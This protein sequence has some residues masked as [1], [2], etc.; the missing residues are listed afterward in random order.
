MGGM[1]EKGVRNRGGEG[2]VRGFSGL[3]KKKKNCAGIEDESWGGREWKDNLNEMGWDWCWT[4]PLHRS[5]CVSARV[6]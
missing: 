4:Q 5:V 3:T 2:R 1:T 6:V